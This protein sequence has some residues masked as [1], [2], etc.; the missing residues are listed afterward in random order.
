MLYPVHSYLDN[1]KRMAENIKLCPINQHSI[2]DTMIWTAQAIED[3][4]DVLR[5]LVREIER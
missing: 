1:A 3:I 2:G 4:V 5:S